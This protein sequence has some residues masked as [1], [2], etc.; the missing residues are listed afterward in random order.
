MFVA[1][2]LP[3]WHNISEI[4]TQTWGEGGLTWGVAHCLLAGENYLPNNI[5]RGSGRT[6][7]AVPVS[8]RG[9]SW[10]FEVSFGDAALISFL[11]IKLLETCPEVDGG[12]ERST[13]MALARQRR[14][15][16]DLGVEWQWQPCIRCYCPLGEQPGMIALRSGRWLLQPQHG[17]NA[18]FYP[19]ARKTR[20]K[21]SAAMA[22][23]YHCANRISRRETEE[24]G[25]ITACVTQLLH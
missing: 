17:K 12:G 15:A 20:K 7:A 24:G 3:R 21:V 5:V 23:Y 14:W 1:P 22:F 19:R 4:H 18:L 25:K 13:A 8:M 6:G 2:H 10:A 16:F 9:E 11:L